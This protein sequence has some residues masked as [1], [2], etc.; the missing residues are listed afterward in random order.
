MIDE[1][2][3]GILIANHAVEDEEYALSREE[4][5]ARCESFR[6]TMRA[7]VRERRLGAS[8]RALDLGHAFYLEVADGD[9]ADGPL[10]WAKAARALLAEAGYETVGIVSHG[11]RW[12]DEEEAFPGT[13]HLGEVSLVTLSNPSEPFR[14]ALAAE[15]ATHGEGED[16]WGAGLYLDTEAAEALG[17]TPKNAPT[18]LD[19]GGAS[20]FRAGR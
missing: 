18:V 10:A 20:F 8:V 6:R 13:E 11:S 5:V 9:H 12:V 19:A 14:R 3:F 2:A 16:A 17:L 1:N 4:F 7:H 15:T